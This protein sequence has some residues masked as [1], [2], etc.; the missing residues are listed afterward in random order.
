VL[1]KNDVEMHDAQPSLLLGLMQA[2]QNNHLWPA[3]AES[4]QL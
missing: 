4:S 2:M 1:T 3:K